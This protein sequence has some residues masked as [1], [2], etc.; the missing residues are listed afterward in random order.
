MITTGIRPD[1]SRL[2]P[3][4]AISYYANIGAEELDALVAYLR[5]LEPV[6]NVVR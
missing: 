4:M 2:L 6:R 1:G 5:S 3:P